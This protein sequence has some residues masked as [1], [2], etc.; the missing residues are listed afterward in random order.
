MQGAGSGFESP[1]VH[2]P[3][4]EARCSYCGESFNPHS[5]EPEDLI[6]WVRFSDEEECGG[7]GYLAVSYYRSGETPPLPW[8]TAATRR[9]V[10]W[11]PW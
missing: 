11:E 6:H 3:L 5:L 2:M 9:I 7:V 4:Y 8:A 1:R 10:R